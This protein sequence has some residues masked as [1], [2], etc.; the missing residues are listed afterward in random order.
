MWQTETPNDRVAQNLGIDKS[1]VSQIRQRCLKTGTLKKNTYP[2][3]KPY[4]KLT[5]TADANSTHSRKETWN[6]SS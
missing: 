3:D 1:T 5:P 6:T 4:R 2:K